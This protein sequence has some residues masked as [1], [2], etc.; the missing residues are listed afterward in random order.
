MGEVCPWLLLVYF[1]VWDGV[2]W[3]VW[4]TWYCGTHWNKCPRGAVWCYF[5]WFLPS[6]P[7]YWVHPVFMSVK[8]LEISAE[9]VRDYSSFSKRVKDSDLYEREESEGSYEEL[10]LC[11]VF[12]WSLAGG[13]G[14]PWGKDT[15]CGWQGYLLGVALIGKSYSILLISDEASVFLDL[16]SFSS[17]GFFR[18]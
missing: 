1:Y 18:M 8:Y 3:W 15:L 11:S 10:K 7:Q 14:P 4:G 5:D 13:S 6:L 2:Y 16:G 9:R 17:G 12:M